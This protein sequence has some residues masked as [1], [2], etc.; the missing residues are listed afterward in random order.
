M[1]LLLV[2]AVFAIFF[3]FSFAEYTPVY[4]D[5]KLLESVYSSLNKIIQKTPDKAIGISNSITHI[6]PKF[7]SNSRNYY[8]LSQM[9]LY[10]D[11]KIENQKM[12]DLSKPQSTLINQTNIVKSSEISF[13]E[14]FYNNYW[15]EI[16]SSLDTIGKCVDH[17][18]TVDNIGKSYNFP[19]ELILATR[20]METN[21]NFYKPTNN[22]WIFQIMSY[23]YWSWELT[24][25]E[26]KQQIIDFIKFVHNK[27]NWQNRS[28]VAWKN[29]INISYNEY[30]IDDLW[31]H[32]FL[33]NW[34][35]KWVL[36]SET[37]Y[38]NWNLNNNFTNNKDWLITVVLK[39][40]K[41]RVDNLK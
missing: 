4:K 15:L 10:I 38:N 41:W 13:Y 33:Y 31:V 39:V 23:N 6:L 32:W 18:D 37:M 25:E 26:F 19:T 12:A 34:I 36:P 35:K 2:W 11:N 22:R 28:Y 21:C 1:K 3:S 7:S 40:L 17:F 9:Q 20:F 30:S 5:Y 24:N 8:V 29:K 14:K 27:R 16:T